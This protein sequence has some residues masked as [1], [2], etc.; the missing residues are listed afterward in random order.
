VVESLREKIHKRS[1][2]LLYVEDD[3]SVRTPTSKL[4]EKCVNELYVA[5]NGEQGLELFKDNQPD[6]VV[7]DITMPV[8]DG[9]EMSA[10]IRKIN[11]YVPIIVTT[12]HYDTDFLIRAIEIGINHYV[13]KP[14]D[15]SALLDKL[16]MSTRLALE[17]KQSLFTFQHYM[18]AIST[19][20]AFSKTDA[21]GKIT[22]ANDIFLNLYEYDYFDIID[23]THKI[24]EHP[25]ND[26]NGYDLLWSKL[27]I[28]Q[29]TWKGRVRTISAK[30]KEVVADVTISPV[31]NLEGEVIEYIFLRDDKTP[32]ITKMRELENKEKDLLEQKLQA[33]KDLEKAKE[34]FLVVFT[35]ELKTPLNST[36]NFSQFIE[37]E[38]NEHKSK[39]ESF[40]M[41]IEFAK[42]IH[43]NGEFMLNV[44]NGIL[45]ISKLKAGKLKFNISAFRPEYVIRSVVKRLEGMVEQNRV[46]TTELDL[47]ADMILK[48]DEFRFDHIVSNIYSNALKYG[49]DKIAIILKSCG[50]GCFVLSIHDNGNGVSD[51][52]KVFE[53]FEQGDDDEQKQRYTKGTGIGLH[54][55][56]L[57]CDGMGV[58]INVEKSELLGGAKFT[59]TGKV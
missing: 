43:A 53:L 9:L 52:Q 33:A 4:L 28:E 27:Q 39:F 44:V 29:K 22:Y 13:S 26:P 11:N 40:P 36:I 55:V 6:I 56:K 20:F 17:Y 35:H 23:K 5:S 31:I 32:L 45:D 15:F 41:L 18:K 10:R 49:K 48:H 8:M 50:D 34:S 3:D 42:Q 37:E 38:L 59:L 25:K 58:D 16:D 51:P 47:D 7:T 57:L 1:L 12:A 30:G 2:K 54:Y 46:V 14:V 19:G 24:L 21:E